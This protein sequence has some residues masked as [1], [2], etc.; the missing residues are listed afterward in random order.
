MVTRPSGLAAWSFVSLGKVL[1]RAGLERPAKVLFKGVDRFGA[2]KDAVG[3][4]AVADAQFRLGHFQRALSGTERAIA[5]RGGE[6]PDAWMLRQGGLL[7][8]VG[9]PEE[10]AQVLLG[11]GSR[12]VAGR[13]VRIKAARALAAAGAW[14][15]ALAML[16][17]ASLRSPDDLEAQRDVVNFAKKHAPLWQRA[18]L[19]A[20]ALERFPHRADWWSL[21]GVA[22]RELGQLDDALVSL[23]RG[24][25]LGSRHVTAAGWLAGLAVDAELPQAQEYVERLAALKPKIGIGTRGIAAFYIDRGEWP[26][27]LVALER[28]M[29]DGEASAEDYYFAGMAADRCL[30]WDLAEQYLEHA[31]AS[32]DAP[33]KWWWRLGLSRE[34]Q[35]KWLEAAEAYAGALRQTSQRAT[36]LQYRLGTVLAA[37]GE[38]RAALDAFSVMYKDPFGPPDSRD[39]RTYR[40][41]ATLPEAFAEGIRLGRSGRLEEA[42]EALDGATRRDE[43]QRPYGYFLLGSL[44]RAMNH[45][46]E[47]LAAYS[48]SILFGRPTAVSPSSYAKAAWARRQS[49]YVEYL[50]TLPI[51]DDVVLYESYFGSKVDCNPLAMFRELRSRR[52]GERF[53]HVWI[54][55]EGTPVPEDVAN[56]PRVILIDRESPAYVRYLATARYLVNNVTFPSF[57]VRREGQTYLNTWHGTPLK[58]LGKDIGTGLMEHDNVARNFLHTS[59]L[60]TPNEHTKFVLTERYEVQGL[61]TAGTGSVG[62]PRSDEMINAS[63]EAVAALR[64]SLGIEA[65][66]TVV[67]Y[68]PTWRGSSDSKDFD[69]E[70]LLGDLNVMRARDD[71]HV[72]FRAHHLAEALLESEE[73]GVSVLPGELSTA[74][75]LAITDVLVSDYSS[76]FFDFLPLHRPI[77]LNV[78][79]LEEYTAERGL[80]FDIDDMPG[81]IVRNREELAAAVHEAVEVG[82]AE[83][84]RFEASVRRFAPHEDGKASVRAVDLLLGLREPERLDQGKKIPLLFH[85]SMLPNGITSS[86]LNLV[87]HLDRERYR[88]VY[89]FDPKPLKV[90][91]LRRE[92]LDQLP[93]DVQRIARS[94]GHL[95]SLE[96]RWA[97]S[98]FVAWRHWGSEEHERLHRRAFAR[99]A[100]RLF[101]GAR[102]AASVEF[103]GYAAFWS[104]LLA[105]DHARAGR[106]VMFFHNRIEA[107]RTTK[108]PELDATLSTARWFDKLVSV[109]EPTGTINKE[110]LAAPF[111]LD[112]QA[113]T[114]ADNLLDVARM[115]EL[116]AQEPPREIS[117]FLEG[118]EG[119]WLTIGRMSPEKGHLKLFEAFK[120]HLEAGHQRDRL[121]VLGMGPLRGE[122]EAW[123]ERNAMGGSILLAGQVPNPFAIMRACQYFVLASD[124]EGQPMVLL[125][126]LTQGL[127]VMA[128]DIVGSRAVLSP[129]GRPLGLLVP[130]DLDSVVEGLAALPSHEGLHPFNVNAYQVAALEG[131]L[132]IIDPR[133]GEHD[134]VA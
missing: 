30:Q 89:L 2:G 46:Q 76:I 13:S 92:R 98:R 32:Q 119:R 128:T 115:D 100:H 9:R 25:E 71:V 35:E 48:R 68:A 80:Y 78:H 123:I 12:R 51:E 62:T 114:W 34:R 75:A 4:Y 60:L 102:F 40:V 108:Y 7:V 87:Q 95:L 27:A 47:A 16:Q 121:V 112:P 83:P 104:A 36:G 26:R 3:L 22:Q 33:A 126:A 8:R 103:D 125:E 53:W 130:N 19:Y 77:I 58:T 23:A 41:P 45:P 94:G 91:R 31:V 69:V 110:E 5:A 97:T 79:D 11:L 131:T 72:I 59:V 44:L 39:A 6:A 99:E 15:D 81:R 74:S 28:R 29:E 42:L 1:H 38:D 49:R 117:D 24:A 67:F 107:E 113:F 10:G 127:R 85:Q 105:A 88:I 43:K 106:T 132:T 86:F 52:R 64:A 50:E 55:T 21:L 93:D 57:F 70:Q 122:L 84:E 14:P 116:G 133:G 73:L 66:K 20:A 129:D 54:V 118:A 65:G 101:G 61:L 82:I 17:A 56:D 124:H 109:S 96:D 90:D 111:A 37:A 63:P 134:A 120:R 18:D